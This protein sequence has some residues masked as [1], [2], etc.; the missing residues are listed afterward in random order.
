MLRPVVTDVADIKKD[1]V[2]QKADLASVKTMLE[3]NE[4]ATI[5]ELRVDMK[6]IRDRHVIEGKKLDIG[7][8]ATWKEL[9]KRYSEMG[10]NH[11]KEYVDSW[12]KEI[13]LTADELRQ[14]RDEATAEATE[15]CER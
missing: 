1:I 9:Y 10:G 2:E 8:I 12:G 14:L 13:G 6:S 3:S 11:F 4:A 5:L 15:R 7:D